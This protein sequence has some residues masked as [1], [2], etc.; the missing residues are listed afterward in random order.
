MLITGLLLVVAQ[1]TPMQAALTAMPMWED[2]GSEAARI[3]MRKNESG[4]GGQTSGAAPAQYAD[5]PKEYSH[6]EICLYPANATA[7][8]PTFAKREQQFPVAELF[9][10]EGQ[11][12]RWYGS[13]PIFYLD[14]LSDKLK[15]K[16][17]DDRLGLLSDGLLSKDG[18][19]HT[20]GERLAT[21]GDEAL[22]HIRKAIDRADDHSLHACIYPIG[23]IQTTSAEKM[24]IELYAGERTRDA[25]A[26]ALSYIARPNARKCYFDMLRRDLHAS[27]A[28][29]IIAKLGWKS[30]LPLIE[31]AMKSVE[32]W[33]DFEAMLLAGRSLEGRPVPKDVAAAIYRLTGKNARQAR[34]T[35]MN[36]K[37]VEAVAV[38]AI[39][40]A[41]SSTK[42]DSKSMNDSGN[43]LLRSL[44]RATV[45][46]L[47]TRAVNAV[48]AK[49]HRDKLVSLLG[50]VR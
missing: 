3:V 48:R 21:K 24:L 18:R 19:A 40:L 12:L 47:L 32:Q 11:G 4:F 35:L 46:S 27:S 31:R 10:G 29:R 49:W 43:D 13:G 34:L 2:A 36:Y 44:D 28:A 1:Q 7:G 22:P 30:G 9:L 39:R 23:L 6:I 14:E 25:A 41:L 45:R 26:A 42:G 17:G 50:L 20:Y 15:L 38:L 33:S 8:K 5:V 16:G 37:D